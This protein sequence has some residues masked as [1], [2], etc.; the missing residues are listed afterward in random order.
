MN[1]CINNTRNLERFQVKQE[2]LHFLFRFEKFQFSFKEPLIK[3]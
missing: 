2:I 3:F 1:N